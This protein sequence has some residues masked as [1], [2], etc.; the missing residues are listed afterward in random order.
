MY[1]VEPG[2]AGPER[3][4]SGW[5]FSPRSAPFAA[6]AGDEAR[7][8][9]DVRF[10]PSEPAGYKTFVFDVDVSAKHRYGL[11][12]VEREVELGLPGLE[13]D[14]GYHLGPAPEGPD[15]FLEI[16]LLNT[17]EEPRSVQVLAQ[18]P[19]FPRERLALPDLI[20]GESLTRLVI[21][22]GG[23]ERLKGSRLVVA[24]VVPAIGGRLTSFVDVAPGP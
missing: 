15:L 14:V 20:P 16:T 24:A 1:I 10:S 4:A 19:G 17:G 22:E 12:R 13:L 7:V 6:P 3:R 5:R 9:I 8:P 23:A 2:G 11:L 21:L 18:A